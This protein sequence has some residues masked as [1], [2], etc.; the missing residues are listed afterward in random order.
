MPLTVPRQ[1]HLQRDYTTLG[2]IAATGEG[3]TTASGA[4]DRTTDERNAPGEGTRVE[5]AT[6]T[7]SEP[8]AP[9]PGAAP[10]WGRG[11]LNYARLE[12]DAG[13][14][15]EEATQDLSFW[16]SRLV[17]GEQLE[18][19]VRIRWVLSSWSRHL[20]EGTRTMADV[21]FGHRTGHNPPTT[22]DRPDQWR[23]VA[24][25]LM[26]H[27]GAYSPDEMNGLHWLWHQ[28]A[29]LRIRAAMQDHI[30]GTSLDHRATRDTPQATGSR[31]PKMSRSPPDRRRAETHRNT[32]GVHRPVE[33]PPL[34]NIAAPSRRS[35]HEGARAVPT[36]RG[37]KATRR[38]SAKKRGTLAD[39]VA[40]AARRPPQRDEFSSMRIWRG[41]TGA[42]ATPKL[43]EHHRPP[44]R[45]TGPRGPAPSGRTSPPFS[46]RPGGSGK[47]RLKRTLARRRAKRPAHLPPPS[48]GQRPI[49]YRED[50]A[51]RTRDQ[52][53]PRPTPTLRKGRGGQRSPQSGSRQAT[54]G[55]SRQP[56]HDASGP[57]ADT[58][59]TGTSSP[60]EPAGPLSTAT[61]CSMP[62]KREPP[63]EYVPGGQPGATSRHPSPA[64]AALDQDW[65]A[66]P[67]PPPRP[68]LQRDRDPFDDAKLKAL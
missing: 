19:A 49:R 15:S 13:D 34:A 23:Y 56:G 35:P 18:L 33:V 1:A 26:T 14:P 20:A 42:P 46:R 57:R 2:Q 4:A 54:K 10:H 41:T 12:G 45:D 66:M 31:G 36:P 22:M 16:I 39:P 17:T 5:A 11:H 24:T 28:R 68:P 67:P 61:P 9:P 8:V 43:G 51:P 29:A 62:R 60:Q 53:S 58:E 6:N 30:S 7:A 38:S 25:R 27:M 32:H 52:G 63:T 37:C 47:Q 44:T 3:Q 55:T 59:M 48:R 65:V 21:T 40:A 50:H 64:D